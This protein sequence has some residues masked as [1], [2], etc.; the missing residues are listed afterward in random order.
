MNRCY[1][2][3]KYKVMTDFEIPGQQEWDLDERNQFLDCKIISDIGPY[4]PHNMVL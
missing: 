4:T 2:I 1:Q 3:Y